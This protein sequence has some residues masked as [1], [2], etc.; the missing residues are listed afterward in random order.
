[1]S[2]THDTWIKHLGASHEWSYLRYANNFTLVDSQLWRYLVNFPSTLRPIL[3]HSDHDIMTRSSSKH[4]LHSY[5]I[6]GE[7]DQTKR[8]KHTKVDWI[9]QLGVKT[10]HWI[11][12]F[13]NYQNQ[14]VTRDSYIRV[15]NPSSWT[16]ESHVQSTAHVWATSPWIHDLNPCLHNPPIFIIHGLDPR[17]I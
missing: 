2:M 15:V 6:H 7:S 11:Q 12:K 1:M 9:P 5:L 13:K 10:R 16:W 8:I 3:L 14:V 4:V 17:F